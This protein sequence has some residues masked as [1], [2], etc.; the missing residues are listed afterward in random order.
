MTA[1]MDKCSHLRKRRKRPPKAVLTGPCDHGLDL[2]ELADPS[3]RLGG[4]RGSVG[5]FDVVELAAHV[6]PARRLHDPLVP[7]LVQR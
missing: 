1:I 5:L 6:R 2:V 7:V 3:H 4:D